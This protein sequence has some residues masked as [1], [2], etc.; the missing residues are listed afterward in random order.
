MR[1]VTAHRTELLAKIGDHL[2]GLPHVIPHTDDDP[3]RVLAST[4]DA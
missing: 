3:S 4:T 1:E 2:L